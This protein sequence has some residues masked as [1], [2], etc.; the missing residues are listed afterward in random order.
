MYSLR[1]SKLA[2]ADIASA[3]KYISKV[4]KSLAGADLQS[5]PIDYFVFSLCGTDYKSAPAVYIR[6]LIEISKNPL[7]HAE[8][9]SASP[10]KTQ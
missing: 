5:V 7:R 6:T 3:V 9:V 1:I 4:L 2:K 10:A 8:L